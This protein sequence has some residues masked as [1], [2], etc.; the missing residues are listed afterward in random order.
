MLRTTITAAIATAAL[1][2][3][4]GAAS[5]MPTPIAG[6]HPVQAHTLVT[7]RPDGGNGSPDPYWADDSFIRSLAITLTGG[8]AGDY[9]YTA[10]LADFGTFTTIPGKQAPNQGP[11]YAG[12]LIKSRVTGIMTGYADFSFTASSL[13]DASLVPASENDHGQVPADDTSTWYELAFPAGTTFGGAGIGPWSWTYDAVVK[14]VEKG[15]PR[16]TPQQWT[17]SMDNGYGDLA[18]DGQITG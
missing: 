12:D 5:A 15:F 8:T 9:T 6:P 4:A 16:L 17:D 3:S 14:T 1:L 10:S 2:A 11:G 18:G 7:D 13:P